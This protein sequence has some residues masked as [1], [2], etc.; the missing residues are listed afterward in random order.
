MPRR[1]LQLLQEY[2][3]LPQGYAPYPQRTDY[4]PAFLPPNS[5]SRLAIVPVV[6]SAFRSPLCLRRA[7]KLT[8]PDAPKPRARITSGQDRLGTL[9]RCGNTLDQSPYRQCLRPP[10]L[11]LQR[12]R[13][14]KQPPAIQSTTD[15][16]RSP[17]FLGQNIRPQRNSRLELT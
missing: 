12:N 9:T 7:L 4:P 11:H 16:V 3:S 1:E 2:H 10:L 13:S 14:V 5:L 15:P 8:R 6:H 17:A